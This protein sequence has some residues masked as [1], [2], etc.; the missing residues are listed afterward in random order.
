MTV[1]AP[2]PKFRAVGAD[3][4]ALVGGKLYSYTAGTSTPKDTY[5]SIAGSANTNP[6]ILDARGECD[7]WLNGNYKL[8]LTDSDDE[9]IWSVDDIRDL[10]SSATLTNAT[11]AGTLTVTSTAVTWSGNPTHSG[12]HTFTSNVI[13]NGNT[14]IGDSSADTLTIRPNS[15]TWT[16]NPTHSGN[17][18]F[19]GSLT[20]TNGVFSTGEINTTADGRIYG[21]ALHNN[22][23]AVTGTTNQYICSGTY[24]PTF[25]S[26]ANI[27]STSNQ[28]NC[29]KWTRVGNVVSVSVDVSVTPTAA[30][31]TLSSVGI[32][33]PIAS[34]LPTSPAF[35]NGSL[36]GSGA[37]CDNTAGVISAVQVLYDGTND[38][39]SALFNAA[40]TN[41]HSMRVCFKYE[42]L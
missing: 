29:G 30:A 32:S 13:V 34:N 28:S 22:A 40:T 17:H 3:G 10:T 15:V 19:S 7:L 39:A 18:T 4:L 1:L 23:N 36:A 6:V 25:T 12:N 8:T 38:R 41:S 14:T 20:V 21:T 31:A 26:V 35:N 42:V 33:L 5:V 37:N 9:V 27:A 11:L 24:T 16:N 2:A